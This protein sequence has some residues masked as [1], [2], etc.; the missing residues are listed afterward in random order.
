MTTSTNPAFPPVSDGIQALKNIDWPLLRTR[1]IRDLNQIGLVLAM[2]GEFI[3]DQGVKL[4]D[5]K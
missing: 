4:A 5:L 2:T 3:H 1:S